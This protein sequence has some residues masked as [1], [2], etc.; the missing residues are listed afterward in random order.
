ME[1][2]EVPDYNKCRQLFEGGLKTLG[3]SNTCVLDFTPTK[4][5]SP[6]RKSHAA[7]I[8]DDNDSDSEN[9]LAPKKRVTKRRSIKGKRASTSP[10]KDSVPKVLKKNL[11]VEPEVKSTPDKK[12]TTTIATQTS[13]ERPKLTPRKVKKEPDDSFSADI[14]Q[15]PKRNGVSNKFLDSS[16]SSVDV[17][18]NSFTDTPPPRSAIKRKHT[19]RLEVEY[20]SDEE[21]TIHTTIKKKGTPVKTAARSWRNSPA[22]VNGKTSSKV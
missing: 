13:L 8:E 3:Y 2:D 21:V 17:I 15:R 19:K 18:D 10:T 5:K 6:K 4:P 11:K 22:I 20:A 14:I 7:D 1:Y 12:L 9:I 16:Q